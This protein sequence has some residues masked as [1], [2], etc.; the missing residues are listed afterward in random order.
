MT[1]FCLL[2]RFLGYFQGK[3]RNTGSH[4][5]LIFF[6]C[7]KCS[8]V[9]GHVANDGCRQVFLAVFSPPLLPRLLLTKSKLLLLLLPPLFYTQTQTPDDRPMVPEP[10]VDWLTE[11][12]KASLTLS[13]SHSKWRV[14]SMWCGRS[15]QCCINFGG[16]MWSIGSLSFG[17]DYGI[18]NGCLG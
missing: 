8:L 11:T 3:Q 12:S 16:F 13:P 2:F 6:C 15:G 17:R 4:L 7:G 1:F 9:E 18:M 10:C 5:G 14:G